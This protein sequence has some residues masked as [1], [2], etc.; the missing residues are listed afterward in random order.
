[1]WKKFNNI[2]GKYFIIFVAFLAHK[3]VS[4][5]KQETKYQENYIVIFRDIT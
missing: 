5:S 2:N 1:M 4:N 3:F